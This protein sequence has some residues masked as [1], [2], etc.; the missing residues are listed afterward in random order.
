M[1]ICVIITN[2]CQSFG[3]STTSFRSG[4][5]Q[6]LIS[7]YSKVTLSQ[8]FIENQK[9]TLHNA[10]GLS[11][12]I[13]VT[14]RWLCIGKPLLFPIGE[15]CYYSTGRREIEIKKRSS[16]LQPSFLGPLII[17]RQN[18][19]SSKLCFYSEITPSS[20]FLLLIRQFKVE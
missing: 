16:L 7:Q 14:T 5:H 15:F 1:R 2:R 8:F 17:P 12:I 10:W 4:P 19:Y 6:L 13:N 9:A 18:H 11:A 20:F 3:Q